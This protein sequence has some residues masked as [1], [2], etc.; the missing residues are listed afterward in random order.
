[1][2]SLNKTQNTSHTFTAFMNDKDHDFVHTSQ[3][4]LRELMQCK[5]QGS[6]VGIQADVLG[7]GM[8]ITGI[9]DI[10]LEE[11][12]TIIVLKQ[13]DTSGYM[14]PATHIDL[15]DINS[16]CPFKSEFKNPFLDNIEKDK[17]WFF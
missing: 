1:M 9:E 13:Y 11:G 2:N 16:I 6:A 3:D 10:V 5:E 14:L 17:S 12:A 4:I 15:R 7:I 8:F